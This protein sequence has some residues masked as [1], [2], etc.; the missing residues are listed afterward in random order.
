MKY[1]IIT[2]TYKRKELLERA[3]ASVL[4]QTHKD[5]E[6]I[7]INDSPFDETYKTFVVNDQRI[8]YYL[9]ERNMG[10]NFSRNSA[11]A[12]VAADSDYIIFLDDDD[13]LVPDT[14]RNFENM[15]LLN[16][17]EKWF[18]TNRALKD[19]TPLTKV[20]SGEGAYSYAFPYLILKQ[21]QGDA[22]HCIETRMVI[23]NK[24][25]FL[26]S[27]KQ[28][29]EW[30]FFYQV[31]LYTKLFYQDHNSTISDGYD[32]GSGL[33]FRKRNFEEKLSTLIKII[34]EAKVKKSI[35]FPFIV[36]ILARFIRLPLQ[37]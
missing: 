32:R 3:I 14:L 11:L 34:R 28:G 25:T 13:Y 5:W 6:M 1:S 18:M 30:F 27:V 12:K 24:I 7:I 9:N 29:E 2:P 10:V 31:G 35:Q 20:P 23:D 21:I 4:A 33:N 26:R 15:I 19:G 8:R 16:G 17:R 22:T 36:Y 37:K